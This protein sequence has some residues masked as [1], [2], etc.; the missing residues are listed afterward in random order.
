MDVGTSNTYMVNLELSSKEFTERFIVANDP[1]RPTHLYHHMDAPVE[2]TRVKV[3]VRD[4][5]C[6]DVAIPVIAPINECGT[7]L[8]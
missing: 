8:R 5:E 1:F 2:I 7:N 6:G 3:T 4:I